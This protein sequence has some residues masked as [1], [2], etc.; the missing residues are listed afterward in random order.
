MIGVS[1]FLLFMGGI[2]GGVSGEISK[3]FNVGMVIGLVIM[4]TG[5]IVGIVG[6]L[7]K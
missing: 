2:I 7:K 6:G 1:M 4:G 3:S 5:F